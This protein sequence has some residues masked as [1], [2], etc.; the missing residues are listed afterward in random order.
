[1]DWREQSTGDHLLLDSIDEITFS[2]RVRSL[3]GRAGRARIIL[4]EI[5][6]P[7]NLSSNSSSRQK[8]N[9]P[10][11]QF[12]QR[13]SLRYGGY[14]LP[15]IGQ[16]ITLTASL[17]AP[18]K[19]LLPSSFDFQQHARFIKI[20]AY[21]AVKEI[22]ATHDEP[23]Q[24]GNQAGNQMGNQADNKS[25]SSPALLL[26]RL[27]TS[28]GERLD[29]GM[30]SEAPIARALLIGERDSM[31]RA[32][33][34]RIRDAGLAHILA[35]SGLHL[36]LFAFGTF[37]LLRRASTLLPNICQSQPI[38]KI[39][40]TT[41]LTAAFCYMLLAGASVPTQRAFIM[42]G[43][44]LCA[45]LCDRSAISLRVVALAALLILALRPE[46]IA[47]AGFQMS[48]AAAASLVAFYEVF[49]KTRH[50]AI[51]GKLHLQALFLL[52][53]TTLIA[54][55]AT[56]PFVVY[57]FGRIA[58]YGLLSNVLVVPIL[59]LVVLPFGAV[60]LLLMPF[61]LESVTLKIMGFGII[62]IRT[63]ADWVSSLDNSVLL[64]AKPPPSFLYLSAAGLFLIV[65]S[66]RRRRLLLLGFFACFCAVVIMQKSPPPLAIFGGDSRSLWLR[67]YSGVYWR[68]GGWQNSFEYRQWIRYIGGSSRYTANANEFAGKGGIWIDGEDGVF[69]CENDK[70]R[71]DYSCRIIAR[72][73]VLEISSRLVA[74]DNGEGGEKNGVQDRSKSKNK[75]RS[76][77]KNKSRNKGRN[78]TEHSRVTFTC[79]QQEP[80]KN[81]RDKPP[82]P[83]GSN[84]SNSGCRSFTYSTTSYGSASYDKATHDKY[85]YDKYD[86][87]KY[88][89]DKYEL[90]VSSL[91]AAHALVLYPRE[92]SRG[93]SKGYSSVYSS[94]SPSA[95][96][97]R[98][99]TAR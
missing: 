60:S 74:S 38:K 58:Q 39:A 48:F 35:I 46:S 11:E 76:K 24:M 91:R 8:S 90:P 94:A 82:N 78:K 5:S 28:I 71:G 14:Q 3:R 7:S 33:L 15:K 36:G 53:T 64:L 49:T 57:H 84:G 95:R 93:Y 18:S 17:L 42:S 41:A 96:G 73:G 66:L 69:R 80:Y 50:N 44:V 20:D 23:D 22:H 75:G 2:A 45:V 81:P 56:A 99:R 55:L 30:G 63:I 79:E 40:A 70:R 83:N 51:L 77:N 1:M 54:S 10:P 87:D 13:I 19:P 29:R 97:F 9:S 68:F 26:A 67:D 34:Q 27:R 65:F 61:G 16:R 6:L 37:I 59:G 89:Y 21:G 32:E 12:P 25:K 52:L 31:A 85:G 88:D 62:W 47:Q 72:G 98:V 4:D 92:Y 43:L 86:Y